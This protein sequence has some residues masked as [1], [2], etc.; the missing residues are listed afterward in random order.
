M[1]NTR[2][3]Q[4]VDKNGVLTTRHKSVDSGRR[5]D[6]RSSGV[7]LPKSERATNATLDFNDIGDNSTVIHHIDD[8]IFTSVEVKSENGKFTAM[9]Q[10]TLDGELEPL[11][12]EVDD[13]SD[14]LRD[15]YSEVK[16]IL[17]SQYG[18]DLVELDYLDAT[19]TVGYAVPLEG[20]K[21]T[22]NDLLDSL[23]ETRGVSLHDDANN[24]DKL[25]FALSD[26]GSDQDDS[27]EPRHSGKFAFDDEG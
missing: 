3:E 10:F 25:V 9:A 24:S 27:F 26:L 5:L 2:P 12:Y 6:D 15:N 4:V 21:T 23:Y 19:L 22:E 16:G 13:L 20:G 11:I 18:A 1:S 14:Y 7:A 8:P 17:M